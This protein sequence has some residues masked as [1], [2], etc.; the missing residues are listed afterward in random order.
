MTN[1]IQIN[2]NQH[3]LDPVELIQDDMPELIPINNVI[4]PFMNYNFFPNLDDDMPPLI[5]Q[6]NI[7]VNLDDEMPPLIYDD[8]NIPVNLDD[9]IPP[10][11]PINDNPGII[12]ID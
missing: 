10:L 4:A 9:A 3:E 7:Q 8:N 5:Y 12:Y 6:N 2:N 11:S 1:P